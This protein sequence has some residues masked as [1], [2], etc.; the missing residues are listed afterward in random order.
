M[1]F[2]KYYHHELKKYK[3]KS[4]LKKPI[5]TIWKVYEDNCKYVLVKITHKDKK[6]GEIVGYDRIKT[7]K[8]YRPL[9]SQRN[10]LN[11]NTSTKEK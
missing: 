3:A 2:N 6:T 8:K 10:N 1:N 11:K 5:Y 9:I 7:S 4:L